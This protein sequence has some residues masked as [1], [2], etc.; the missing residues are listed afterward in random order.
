MVN[1]RYGAVSF[2]L[3]WTLAGCTLLATPRLSP[4]T[5]PSG[6]TEIPALPSTAPQPPPSVGTRIVHDGIAPVLTGTPIEIADLSGRIVFD[7]FEDVFAMD[8][9]GSNVVKVASDPAG[10]E[11]DGAWSP[12]GEWVV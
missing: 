9:D 12:D 3:G 6:T 5:A 7:D 8:V 10:S 2:A 1:R 11:F 4:S